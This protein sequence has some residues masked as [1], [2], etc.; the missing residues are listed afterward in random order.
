M[1]RVVHAFIRDGESRFPATLR[2]LRAHWGISEPVPLPADTPRVSLCVMYQ[3]CLDEIHVLSTYRLALEADIL[4][5]ERGFTS[6][7]CA[8]RKMLRSPDVA[9]SAFAT[10]SPLMTGNLDKSFL[11]SLA[12]SCRSLR[13]LRSLPCKPMF[14]H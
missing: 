13:G 11:D 5:A 9:F 4:N 10:T 12:A 14:P 7:A 8:A 1:L 2:T 3:A 6:L